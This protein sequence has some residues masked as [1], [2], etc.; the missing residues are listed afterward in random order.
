MAGSSALHASAIGLFRFARLDGRKQWLFQ[1]TGCAEYIGN[2]FALLDSVDAIH[3]G[4]LYLFERP[5]RPVDLDSSHGLGIAQTKL[6]S[7]V[8]RR[9][10]ATAAE[11]VSAL[12][13]VRGC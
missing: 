12:R 11:N 2:S 1:G 8:I 10:E 6:D 4:H 3:L 7:G 9:C 5:A 13:L